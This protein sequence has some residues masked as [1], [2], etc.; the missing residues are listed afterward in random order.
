MIPGMQDLPICMTI[1]HTLWLHGCLLPY[2]SLRRV[3]SEFRAAAL[4]HR[5]SC[6]SNELLSKKLYVVA[7][8]CKLAGID[9]HGKALHL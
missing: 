1:F 9:D 7:G 8:S 4:Q 3:V 5:L 2:T 6:S